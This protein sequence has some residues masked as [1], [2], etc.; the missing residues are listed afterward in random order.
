MT[1]KTGQLVLFPNWLEHSVMPNE[2][3]ETRVSIPMNAVSE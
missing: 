1:P 3:N 2:S